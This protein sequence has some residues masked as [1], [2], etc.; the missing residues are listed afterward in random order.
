MQTLPQGLSSMQVP[1]ATWA[2]FAN[3]G[4][5][6]ETI[7]MFREWLLSSGYVRT[8]YSIP[9]IEVYRDGDLRDDTYDYELWFPIVKA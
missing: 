6:P 2:I 7:E 8:D 3:Q 4:A 1:A 5:I 9:D